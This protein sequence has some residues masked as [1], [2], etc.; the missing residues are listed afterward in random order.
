MLMRSLPDLTEL[1]LCGRSVSTSTPALVERSRQAGLSPVVF[2]EPDKAV[3]GAQV[4]VHLNSASTTLCSAGSM[5]AATLSF[6]AG[7]HQHDR[8]VV[9]PDVASGYTAVACAVAEGASG[10]R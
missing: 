10:E 8:H 4:V 1:R 6:P 7:T 2:D 9:G 3:R 5:R